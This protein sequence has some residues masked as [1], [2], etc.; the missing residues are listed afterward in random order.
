MTPETAALITRVAADRATAFAGRPSLIRRPQ[1]I[2]QLSE[3]LPPGLGVVKDHGQVDGAA[4]GADDLR[5]CALVAA[6]GA[7]YGVGDALKVALA[8]LRAAR[9]LARRSAALEVGPSSPRS[10]RDPRLR[11]TPASGAPGWPE[12]PA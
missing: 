4:V 6:N 7:A 1:P 5:R 12:N 2:D 10:Q 8:D 9:S 11:P 3:A